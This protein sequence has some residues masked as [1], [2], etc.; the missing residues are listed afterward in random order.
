MDDAD[1]QKWYRLRTKRATERDRVLIRAVD[2]GDFDTARACIEQYPRSPLEDFALCRAAKKG[3]LEIVRLLI[4]AGT[5]VTVDENYPIRVAAE[6]NNTGLCQLLL[7]AGADPS[8]CAHNAFFRACKAGALQTAQMFAGAA[9]PSALVRGLRV[10]RRF[11]RD[12]VVTWLKPLA[13]SYEQ[14][15]FV[16]LCTTG[17]L[18]FVKEL[19]VL[20]VVDTKD[21]L[22]KA[23]H[24]TTLAKQTQVLAWLKSLPTPHPQLVSSSSSTL[25][26]C[27]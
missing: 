20:N 6:T 4:M 26:S 23:I 16:A 10:A 27:T 9:N 2:A 15:E 14:E 19:Y 11:A 25:V 18:D 21:V 17:S 1:D 24:A 22:A 13:H 5:P 7:D 8:A 3:H 12:P